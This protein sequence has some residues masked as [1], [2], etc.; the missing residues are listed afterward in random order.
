LPVIIVIIMIAI[1]SIAVASAH[2]KR[3]LKEANGE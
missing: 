2:L 1:I 3:T